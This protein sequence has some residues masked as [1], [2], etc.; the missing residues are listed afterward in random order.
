MRKPFWFHVAFRGRDPDMATWQCLPIDVKL[1]MVEE[2]FEFCTTA[3][4]YSCKRDIVSAA[5]HPNYTTH[6]LEPTITIDDSPFISR[7]RPVFR[8]QVKRKKTKLALFYPYY[9][10]VAPSRRFHRYKEGHY[11]S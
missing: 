4:I 10:L 3:S 8:S 2:W 7:D 5:R 11:S 9:M 1:Y 6:R